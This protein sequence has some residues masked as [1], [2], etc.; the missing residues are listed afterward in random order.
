MLIASDCLK[1]RDTERPSAQQLLERVAVL[2]ESPEYIG[3]ARPVQEILNE[4]EAQIQE[5]QEQIPALN[6]EMLQTQ[7]RQKDEEIQQR[8]A[9]I[10]RFQREIIR[11]Q[12]EVFIHCRVPDRLLCIITSIKKQLDKIEG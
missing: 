9:D 5:A 10:S 8:N 12:V 6:S 4:R 3:S 1:D 11:L 2:K 7:L